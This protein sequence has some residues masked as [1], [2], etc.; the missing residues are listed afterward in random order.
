MEERDVF[1]L[2]AELAKAKRR[3]YVAL[4]VG[5][6]ALLFGGLTTVS[7]FE[8]GTLKTDRQVNGVP[9]V[10]P[11]QGTY[12]KNGQPFDGQV[13]MSFALFNQPVGGAP[14]WVGTP[15]SI[16]VDEGAFSVALGAKPDTTKI[17]PSVFSESA[18]YIELSVAG[19]PLSPR[20]RIAP[21]P[22]AIVAAMAAGDFT[23]PGSLDV[24]GDS[25]FNGVVSGLANG[26]TF[27]P[28]VTLSNNKG[29][30]KRNT[31]VFLAPNDGK[32][33]CSL[34]GLTYDKAD[35]SQSV[36]L[37]SCSVIAG[38]TDWTLEFNAINGVLMGCRAQCFRFK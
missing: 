11:Y 5:I 35:G 21:A 7:A 6:A 30:A 15:R 37:G 26:V 31:P 4:G 19:V 9:A 29:I 8:L 3:S 16:Q 38:H 10:L 1:E 27:M 23:V 22:Q 18:L 14:L 36:H 2:Y 34:T 24:A 20:Q 12:S 28:A 33:F 32:H 13:N 17:Q 25:S